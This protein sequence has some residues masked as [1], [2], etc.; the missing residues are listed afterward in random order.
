MVVAAVIL[1]CCLVETEATYRKP[2]FNGSIFGKRA[3]P[4]LGKKKL[5]YLVSTVNTT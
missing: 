1:T 4:S 5:M 3:P 2:P